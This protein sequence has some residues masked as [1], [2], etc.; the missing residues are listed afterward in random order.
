[1]SSAMLIQGSW[2]WPFTNSDTNR[3]WWCWHTCRNVAEPWM[4]WTLTW[5]T[6][7]TWG[8]LWVWCQPAQ[9]SLAMWSWLLLRTA[10]AT[11]S[12]SIYSCIEERLADG[13]NTSEQL[14]SSPQP[15]YGAQVHRLKTSATILTHDLPMSAVHPKLCKT[16][17]KDYL[18]RI[19]VSFRKDVEDRS[20]T[21]LM[22]IKN[23]CFKSL[24]KA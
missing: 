1:M 23:Q 9:L 24:S 21:C 5:L 2:M 13:R 17:M 22:Q 4:G 18:Y 19:P 15:H 12:T 11:N 10:P 16:Q 14:L 6:G 20:K 7:L 3:D 8:F